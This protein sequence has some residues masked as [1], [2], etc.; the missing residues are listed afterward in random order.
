MSIEAENA[1]LEDDANLLHQTVVKQRQE[2]EAMKKDLEQFQMAL[3][4][5]VELNKNLCNYQQG[6]EAGKKFAELNSE[7][8]PTVAYLNGVAEGKKHKDALVAA[9]YRAAA[10]RIY[11][12][13]VDWHGEANDEERQ[14]AID[15]SEEIYALTP[16]DAEKALREFGMEVS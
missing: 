12:C 16:A 14:K 11:E 4:E 1:W 6:F 15:Y 10:K 5:Q 7:D 13:F 3:A 2:I 8:V 9:A